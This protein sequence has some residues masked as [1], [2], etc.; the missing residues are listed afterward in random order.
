MLSK[1]NVLIFVVAIAAITGVTF[2]AGLVGYIN[3]M[4]IRIFALVALN[5]ANGGIAVGSMLL[6]GMKINIDFREKKQYMIGVLIALSLSLVIAV[7]PALCGLSLIGGHSDFSWFSFLFDLF[8]YMLIIGPVEELIF[9]VY[10]QELIVDWLPNYKWLGVV[11]AAFL[12][13]LWHI[14]NGSIIQVLFTFG[15]GLVFG[16]AKYKIKDCGY[17]GVAVGHGL[18]DFLNTVVRMF[19]L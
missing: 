2:L 10:M 6:S 3:I 7:I 5:L 16:F 4:P 12:F 14:I 15:I 13:G 17:V 18:Y 11:I 19:I 1:K 8:F 9:R